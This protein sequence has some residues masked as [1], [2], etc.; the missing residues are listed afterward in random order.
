MFSSIA[1][2]LGA[3][4]FGGD[5]VVTHKCCIVPRLSDLLSRSRFVVQP[6]YFTLE[7]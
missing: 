4:G 7:K 1:A 3:A 2:P 6:L 5:V